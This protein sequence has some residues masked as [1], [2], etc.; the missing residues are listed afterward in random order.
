MKRRKWILW[1]SIFLSLAYPIAAEAGIRGF[2]TRCVQAVVG[3]S[4]ASASSQ[5]A[6]D[7]R[8]ELPFG[9]N[10]FFESQF[11]TILG[12]ADQEI[13]TMVEQIRNQGT[14]IVFINTEGAVVDHPLQ[15]QIS[16]DFAAQIFKQAK[17]VDAR[18]GGTGPSFLGLFVGKGNKIGDSPA[19]LQR[20]LILL[21]YELMPSPEDLKK[22]LAHEFVHALIGKNTQDPSLGIQSFDSK[23]A[24]Y[25]YAHKRLRIL[26][27][28][29][30]RQLDPAD[31]EA[32]RDFEDFLMYK[33]DILR[34]SLELEWITLG[35]EFDTYF[36]ELHVASPGSA[37]RTASIHNLG[38]HFREMRAR[39]QKY[40]PA[41][42][43]SQTPFDALD[44]RVKTVY[45]E[46]VQYRSQLEGDLERVGNLH[47]AL[48]GAASATNEMESAARALFEKR[49][50]TVRPANSL[51][52]AFDP[53]DL[54]EQF[55][56]VKLSK[57]PE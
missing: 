24:E 50:L 33:F 15:A 37:F 54:T 30:P 45:T 53:L 21:R 26:S 9:R 1:A 47:S 44:P 32:K 27:Q 22:T 13:E 40:D 55:L 36:L 35:N 31:R 16:P 4:Q 41:P 43:A 42:L 49:E 52:A 28:R 2:V 7:V 23:Y 14:D 12:I 18:S 11:S 57:L 38:F 6:P 20:P 19:P 46:L 10:V 8:I 48:W 17:Q 3:N 34:L 29:I 39:L 5:P 56:R 51:D 25:E